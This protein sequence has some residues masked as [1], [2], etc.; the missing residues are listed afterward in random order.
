MGSDTARLMRVK[1][2]LLSFYWSP[3]QTQWWTAPRPMTA[4]PLQ[5]A[6]PSHLVPPL[7][8]S[9][10]TV[11]SDGTIDQSKSHTVR[12]GQFAPVI[13]EFVAYDAILIP[14]QTRATARPYILKI[15]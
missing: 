3:R 8:E 6:Y 13:V 10:L 2:L 7:G 15:D 4:L 11:G 5:K 9:Q 12:C 14:A 1:I